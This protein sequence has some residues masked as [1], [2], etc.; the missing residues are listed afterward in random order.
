MRRAQP[1]PPGRPA[2]RPTPRDG[3]RRLHPGVLRGLLVLL[4][5]ALPGGGAGPA[6]AQPEA[7]SRTFAAPPERVFTVAESVLRSLGWEIDAKDAAVGW[8]L[9]ESR[10]VDFKDFGVYGEGTRHKL[11]LTIKGTGEGRTRVTVERELWKE[12]RIL[13]LKERK[14]L[15]PTDRAVETAV[16][17]AIERSL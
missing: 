15:Q 11:R 17:D 5:L 12:E 9:T 1:R 4:A 7:A 2:A 16:L 8:I 13:W 3:L 10:G 14:P 6:A